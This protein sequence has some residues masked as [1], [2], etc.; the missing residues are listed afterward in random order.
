MVSD[1]VGF[2]DNIMNIFVQVGS[3]GLVY[4]HS[5]LASNKMR[6]NVVSI[7]FPEILV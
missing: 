5:M 1:I 2:T 3:K 4:I 7:D 6:S